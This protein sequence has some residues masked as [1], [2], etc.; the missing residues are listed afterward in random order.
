[1]IKAELWSVCTPPKCGTYTLE[2]HLKAFGKLTRPRHAMLR[3]PGE[4][5]MPIR[6]PLRRWMSM[7]RF[8]NKTGYWMPEAARAGVLTF[9]EAWVRRQDHVH[10]AP[11]LTQFAEKYKPD[12]V[13]V[14]EDDGIQKL[15]DHVSEKYGLPKMVAT[16][17][18][19]TIGPVKTNFTD[20]DYE[21]L[22][23]S[24]HWEFIHQWASEDSSHFGIPIY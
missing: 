19:K 22:Q 4:R 2:R 8:L 21:L 11:N 24:P 12:H 3:W 14:M 7:Y 17:Q 1:M 13:F 6:R 18:N 9:A 16:V 5:L 10:W 20:P 15:L 23:T